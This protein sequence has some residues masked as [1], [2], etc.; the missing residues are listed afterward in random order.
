MVHYSTS[1]PR[2]RCR[3]NSDLSLCLLSFNPISLFGWRKLCIANV[4]ILWINYRL[5]YCTSVQT[6]DGESARFKRAASAAYTD[7]DNCVCPPGILIHVIG[8]TAVGSW[9]LS[10]TK[11]SHGGYLL[12]FCIYVVIIS[13]REEIFLSTQTVMWV[14]SGCAH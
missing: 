4:C 3:N 14:A 7:A 2:E 1:R 9:H 5:Y 13:E 11:C 12:I 10:Y 6:I 8:F